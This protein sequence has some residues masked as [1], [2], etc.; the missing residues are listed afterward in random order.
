MK[1]AKTVASKISHRLWRKAFEV[2][3]IHLGDSVNCPLIFHDGGSEG[4]GILRSMFAKPSVD[5]GKEPS[6]KRSAMQLPCD[7]LNKLPGGGRAYD[8][9]LD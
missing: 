2:L 5:L 6:Q 3:E 7:S 9:W 4:T 8:W 1:K